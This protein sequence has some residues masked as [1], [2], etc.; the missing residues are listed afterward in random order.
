MAPDDDDPSIKTDLANPL[1][2]HPFGPAQSGGPMVPG[3]RLTLVEGATARPWES[4][5]DRCSIGLHPSNDLVIDEPT[6]SRFHCEIRV[7]DEGARVRDLGSRNGVILDGVRV[8]EGCPRTGSILRLGRVALRFDFKG[9]TNTL[10]ISQNHVFGTIVGSSVSMRTAF[11]LMER[12][13][14]TKVHVLLEGE[15][16]TGK[17]Q[18]AEAIHRASARRDKPF[19]IVDC[20]AIPENLLESE[21]FGHEKGAFTGAVA[22]R[23][24]AFEEANGGTIFLDEIGE[25]PTD[26]QPK[27]LRVLENREIRRIGTNQYQTVDVRVIAATN[28]DLRT[29]VNEARFRSDLYYRLAVIKIVLPPLR[30]RPDDIVTISERILRSLGADDSLITHLKT[31]EFLANLQRAAWPGNVRELRNYLERCLVFEEALPVA[32]ESNAPPDKPSIDARLPYADA[33]KRALDQ[34]ERHYVEALLGLH[35]GKVAAAASAAGIDRVYLYKL[36]RRH[37]L[38]PE[39]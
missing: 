39:K 18:A 11:A 10:P 6:V 29:E 26:L 3:F 32:D 13:A 2:T 37:G 24:G 16:G 25:L 19:L 36:M 28:R 20:G 21:L 12:A 9:D 7:G 22:R 14:E 15:T 8:I 34:F 35:S 33:R 4:Q 38:R 27:L 31:P 5:G 30:E 23:I 1:R 17:S